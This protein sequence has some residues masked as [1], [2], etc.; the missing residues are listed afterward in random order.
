M[1]IIA[2]EVDEATILRL[3]PRCDAIRKIIPDGSWSKPSSLVAHAGKTCGNFGRIS[4][5]IHSVDA[6]R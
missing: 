5:I 2:I 3:K 6:W 4:R 1:C